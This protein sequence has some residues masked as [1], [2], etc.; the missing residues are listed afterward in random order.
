MDQLLHLL[1]SSLLFVILLKT[2]PIWLAALGGAFTQKANILNLALEGMMLVGAFF[3]ISVGAATQSALLAVLAAVVAGIVLSLLFAWAS[4]YL[5]ADFLVAGLGINLLAQGATVFLLERLYQNEG[6][7]SP[8]RFPHLAQIHLGPLANIPLIGP[9]LEGQTVI[10]ALSLV[11]LPVSAWVLYRTRFGL[12]VR[13]VG[14]NEDAVIAAGI[15]PSRVK[16]VTVIISGALSGLAGAQLA[17]GTLGIFV[18]GMSNGRGY[19]ALAALTF[20]N[21][22]PLGTFIASLIFGAADAASDRLQFLHIPT[23]FV[24][25]VP[26][27][28]TVIALVIAALRHRFRARVAEA[29]LAVHEELA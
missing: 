3:A 29:R 4:L 18:R 24:L 21:A 22:T 27:W 28:V 19:I 7:F 6:N 13:A 15:N 12:R 14:E 9:A 5:R 16:L 10:V 20:G 26:Y 11:L 17:M 23:Q 8:E 1:G 25:M 2:T